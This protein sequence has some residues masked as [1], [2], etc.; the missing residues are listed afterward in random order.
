MANSY[1]T[2]SAKHVTQFHQHNA[3]GRMPSQNSRL[4]LWTTEEVAR[5]IGWMEANKDALRGLQSR[6]Y[7]D[8]REALWKEDRDMTWQRV[9]DKVQNMKQAW[10]KGVQLRDQSGWGLR[11]QDNEPAVVQKLE[12]T[13]PFFWRLDRIWGTGPQAPP[14]A[15]MA[16]ERARTTREDSA[17]QPDGDEPLHLED[18]VESQPV[19]PSESTP[20]APTPPPPPK[21]SKASA[22]PEP[23]PTRGVKRGIQASLKDLMGESQHFRAEIAGKKLK[24]ELILQERQIASQ[25][26]IASIQ[27]NSAKEIARIQAETQERQLKIQVEAQQ[28]QFDTLASL[29][30]LFAGNSGLPRPGNPRDSGGGGQ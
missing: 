4:K 9:R 25:E 19:T 28:K 30:S 3:A 29:V 15:I 23:P 20:S 7:K 5:L 8:A 2:R 6:W 17:N 12:K 22:T 26:R 27:A 18:E 1:D 21:V 16:A 24:Q 14:L 11:V 13:C 10:K